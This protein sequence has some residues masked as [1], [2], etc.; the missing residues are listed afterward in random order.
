MP[1]LR[2]GVIFSNEEAWREQRKMFVSTLH[3]TGFN[4]A[5]LDEST[6]RLMDNV[7]AIVD[8]HMREGTQVEPGRFDLTIMDYVFA[9]ACDPAA[10]STYN[11][12][13]VLTRLNEA[14]TF[15]Y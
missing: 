9:L 10:M 8:H 2:Y 3:K 1:L 7:K 13:D 14:R 12:H 11:S 15:I 5:K 4:Q 6:R